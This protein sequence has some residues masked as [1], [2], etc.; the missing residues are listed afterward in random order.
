[1]KSDY[2]KNDVQV[3]LDE[4]EEKINE[5]PDKGD[6]CEESQKVCLR[7]A[8]NDLTMAVN[9]VEPEDFNLNDEEE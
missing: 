7:I 6:T 4:L 3:I 1:M 8:L 9:G 5:L 2:W